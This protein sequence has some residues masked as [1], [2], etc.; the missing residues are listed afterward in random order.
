VGTSIQ[1]RV[2]WI[3]DKLGRV[4]GHQ[5]V[6]VGGPV[7]N[8]PIYGVD[9]YGNATALVPPPGAITG[10]IPLLGKTPQVVS[11]WT[12]MADINDFLNQ[13]GRT[14]G[15]WAIQ[16]GV[17]TQDNAIFRRE[18]ASL[19]IRADA[20]TGAN[21][22]VQANGTIS[23]N[24]SAGGVIA[25]LVYVAKIQQATATRITLQIGPSGTN[26]NQVYW[27]VASNTLSIGW[28]ML[29]IHTSENGQTIYPQYNT[30]NPD[31]GGAVTAGASGLSGP[32]AWTT[33]G[34]GWNP[35]TQ[36]AAFCRVQFSCNPFGAGAPQQFW[37][38]GIYFGGAGRPAVVF[39]LDG[40]YSQLR[41]YALPIASQYG[42][43][44]SVCPIGTNGTIPDFAAISP[45]IAAA[46]AQGWDV[47]SHTMNHV[48][49]ATYS[50]ANKVA[51]EIGTMIDI[52]QTTYG[53][54]AAC[55]PGLISP[56][57]VITEQTAWMQ[58]QVGIKFTR[59]GAG[60]GTQMYQT[61]SLIG[62]DS[63]YSLNCIGVQ[64]YT[65]TSG[66]AINGIA[67]TVKYGS[68]LHMYTHG[69]VGPLDKVN[70]GTSFTL[71]ATTV[72]GSNLLACNV[73]QYTIPVGASVSGS[74]IQGGSTITGTTG[75]GY[76]MSLTANGTGATTATIG[77]TGGPCYYGYGD[78][79]SVA[80]NDTVFS[81]S[82]YAAAWARICAY[83]SQQVA[84]GVLDNLT[85]S[86]YMNRT[87]LNSIPITLPMVDSF[88]VVVGASPYTYTAP[89]PQRIN[90]TGG[91]V[92]VIA[93]SRNGVTF[94]TTGLTSGSFVVACGEQLQI[95]YSVAPT[96]TASDMQ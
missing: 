85:Y 6:N 37:L 67:G 22:N 91:T 13:N 26:Y 63:P 39:S 52:M 18:G 60:S 17:G 96:V 2:D 86:Q 56:N 50:D 41:N 40:A 74:N 38:E 53:Q 68:T 78:N 66:D 34:T 28:N 7:V 64:A 90:I 27:D 4:I 92:T 84:A 93:I 11:P 19:R 46:A 76:T 32:W 33:G 75:A 21:L 24:F 83:V 87:V 8:T 54:S 23:W 65:L 95:T 48:S 70:G 15:V 25:I 31:V 45:S 72:N 73:N 49:A 1:Q 12:R 89:R 94:F 3:I 51:N 81:A 61:D 47:I 16:N 88:N 14:A 55:L 58:G 62:C 42:I 77:A 35:A 9:T 80:V 43:V 10:N 20:M 44:A 82:I 79:T 69:V 36:N 29:C 57:N 59:G 30:S 71:A 5:P